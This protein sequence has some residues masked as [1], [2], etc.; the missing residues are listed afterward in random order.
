M[1]QKFAGE[2]SM[3]CEP[4]NMDGYMSYVYTNVPD[5]DLVVIGQNLF[6]TA[7]GRCPVTQ[8][9]KIKIA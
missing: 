3:Q 1:L 5:L 7:R 8:F 4:R 2:G 9:K 6:T